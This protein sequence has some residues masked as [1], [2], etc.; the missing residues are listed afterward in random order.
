M[1]LPRFLFFT[2]VATAL[3]IFGW[4][5]VVL[6][7]DPTQE[8]AVGPALFFIS[9]YCAVFGIVLLIGFF[10]RL[11]IH[12]N[13]PPFHHVG[14]SLRQSFWLATLLVLALVLQWNSLFEW[15][16]GVLMVIGFS[17]LE[18]F[19]LSRTLEKRHVRH[20]R[21]EETT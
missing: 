1:S 6:F 4:V 8:G 12:R 10:V 9:L 19:F 13:E 17:V 15:W 5:L 20:P 21:H 11:G 3:C 14:I 2:A 18:A 16:I 7:I